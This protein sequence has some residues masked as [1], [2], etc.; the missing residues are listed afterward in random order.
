MKRTELKRGKPLERKTSMPR[1]KGLRSGGEA[2]ARKAAAKPKRVKRT[3]PPT[4]V[5]AV[6]AERS[7]GLCELGIVCLGNA[8]A[9]DPSHRIAKGMG[10]TRDP[11]SNTASNNLHA[12]RACHDLVERDPAAAYNNGWKIRRGAAD[13]REVPVRHW[14][15]GWVYLNDDGSVLRSALTAMGEVAP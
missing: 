8:A 7:G 6:L 4:S 2:L 12:C 14:V 10:G 15:H 9:V 11:R 3:G 5:M 1:G 13:P